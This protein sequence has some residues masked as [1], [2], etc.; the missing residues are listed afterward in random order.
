[1]PRELLKES[2]RAI[3]ED[4]AVPAVVALGQEPLGTRPVGLLDEALD[5]VTAFER[6][7]AADVA[8]PGLGRGRL[9]PERD[10]PVVGGQLRRGAGGVAE[11]GDVGD[12]VVARA[13]QHDRLGRQPLGGERDRRR[14]VL[15]LG[16][17]DHPGPRKARRLGL[18]MRAM[19]L[20]GDHDRRGEV[21][22]IGAR[23][24]VASNSVTSLDQRQ[25]RLGR[26]LA[27][28]RPQARAAAAA[29][30]RPGK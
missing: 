29:Q 11:R 26:V 18:D 12:V 10:Q 30:H 13:H 19:R 5:L 4:P 17:D 24:S 25:E 15:G 8:E 9:D 23:P 20:A 21:L 3:D 6:G 7:A 14:G 16:L 27:A 28:A 22:G 2:A 1:M